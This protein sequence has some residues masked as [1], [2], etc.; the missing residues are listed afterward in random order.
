M[1]D[2]FNAAQAQTQAPHPTIVYVQG[3]PESGRTR[4]AGSKTSHGLH[5]TLTIFTLGCW[6][7]VWLGMTVWNALAR[8]D[9]MHRTAKALT[10]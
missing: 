7:P 9:V 6:A 10:K 2:T 8:R 5:L 3:L 1:S 4:V